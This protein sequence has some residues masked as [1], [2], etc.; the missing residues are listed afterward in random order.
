[1]LSGSIVSKTTLFLNKFVILSIKI[2]AQ[3]LEYTIA[4]NETDE[5]YMQ[6]YQM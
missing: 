3:I 2:I 6:D 5:L 1:M 4:K